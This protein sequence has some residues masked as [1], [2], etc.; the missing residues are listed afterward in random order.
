MLPH[1]LQRDT[2]AHLATGDGDRCVE[3]V[4]IGELPIDAIVGYVEGF[5]SLVQRI[6]DYNGALEGSALQSER[7]D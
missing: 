4:K 3:E 2:Y 5:E 6:V 7:G 1:P